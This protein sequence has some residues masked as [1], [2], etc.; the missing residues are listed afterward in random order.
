MDEEKSED[1]AFNMENDF[2]GE[3]EE[4]KKK[5]NE[6]EKKEEEDKQEDDEFG[7]VEE[8]N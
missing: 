6:E 2:Q 1:D 7:S 3:I 8:D 4:H 5:N